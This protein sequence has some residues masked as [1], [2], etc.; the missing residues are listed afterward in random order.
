MSPS[1]WV[2]D[3]THISEC[4]RLRVPSDSGPVGSCHLLGAG[5]FILHACPVIYLWLVPGL[6]A[7]GSNHI[8]QLATHTFRYMVTLLHNLKSQ[9]G[10]SSKDKQFTIKYYQYWFRADWQFQVP[11][12]EKV[13][14]STQTKLETLLVL[15]ALIKLIKHTPHSDSFSLQEIP[16]NKYVG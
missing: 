9:S 11:Y 7:K 5:P 15:Q 6:M 10:N 2:Q 12:S 4:R 14:Y 13:P 1:Q 3:Q 16:Q 8:Q